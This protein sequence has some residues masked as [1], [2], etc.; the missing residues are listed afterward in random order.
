[1]DERQAVEA[2]VELVTGYLQDGENRS[3]P[4]FRTVGGM[5]EPD[6]VW[7]AVQGLTYLSAM[8]VTLIG[9]DEDEDPAHV[10]REVAAGMIE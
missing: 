4:T 8:L 1:M 9:E 3:R 10:L 7:L 6:E 2:A 5:L